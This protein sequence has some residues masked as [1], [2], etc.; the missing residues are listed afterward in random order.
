MKVWTAQL[1]KRDEAK[2]RTG[3]PVYDVTYKTGDRRF[4][5][6]WNDVMAFKSGKLSWV[7]FTV[8]YNKKLDELFELCE[9]DVIRFCQQENIVLACYCK[10]KTQCHRY[11][12]VRKLREFCDK[13]GIPFMYGGEI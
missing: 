6:E 12:L 2:R 7:H 8:R 11:L 4:A 1:R 5:P 10:S 3:A 9:H 13:R